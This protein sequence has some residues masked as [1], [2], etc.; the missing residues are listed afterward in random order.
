ML[1]QNVKISQISNLVSDNTPRAPPP[2][3]Q[4]MMKPTGPQVGMIPKYVNNIQYVKFEIFLVAAKPT[5][6]VETNSS[7]KLFKLV[8]ESVTDMNF[9]NSSQNNFFHESS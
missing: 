4:S 7:I 2:P 3:P 9:D 1:N 8:M 5:T 6:L